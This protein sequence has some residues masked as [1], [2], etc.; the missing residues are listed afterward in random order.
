MSQPQIATPDL[1]HPPRSEAAQPVARVDSLAEFG[2]MVSR[3]L[4]Q[5]RRYGGRLAVLWL[6]AQLLAR[7]GQSWEPAAREGLMQALS[8]RL[9]SR[10]RSTDE[11]LQVGEHS[12]AVLLLDAGEAEAGIVEQ[13]LM[14]QLSGPYGVGPELMYVALS[15]GSA[16]FP[17]AGRH[18]ADLAESARSDLRRRQ[19]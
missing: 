18:G 11:V 7:E 6:E 17:D 16:A 8:R 14:Q 12:F 2:L 5:C 13:R 19:G 9:R 3:Q 1:P 10:V 4:T 15:L